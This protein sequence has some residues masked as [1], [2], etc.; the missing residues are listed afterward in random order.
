MSRLAG[1]ITATQTGN[2]KIEEV[3]V[4]R[5]QDETI[6]DD[7][8]GEVLTH[9]RCGVVLQMNGFV[10]DAKELEYFKQRVRAALINEVFGEFRPLVQRLYQAM[11]ERNWVELRTAL[12]EL[13]EALFR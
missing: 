9:Y 11:F 2:R 7:V 5:V 10:R 1:L 8:F 12:D 4:L 13:D 3:S 6:K